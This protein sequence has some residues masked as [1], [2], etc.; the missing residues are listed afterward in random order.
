MKE[1]ETLPLHQPELLEQSDAGIAQQESPEAE[2]TASVKPSQC[3]VSVFDV[4]D[5]TFRSAMQRPLHWSVVWSD[6]MMTMF[7]LFLTM[8]AYQAAHQEFL[9]RKTPEIVGG[10]TIEALDS[11]KLTGQLQPINPIK[12]GLPFV[13]AG[14]LKKVERV[15]TNDVDIGFLPAPETAEKP[16]ASKTAK[17]VNSINQE[18]PKNTAK[19][20][21][22]IPMPG[23]EN[24][25]QSTRTEEQDIYRLSKEA[26]ENNKLEKFAS[27]DLVPDN[28]MRIIL[29][30]DLLFSTGQAELSASAKGSLQKLTEIMK[31]TPYM[32]NVVGH[33]D[34]IPM[35]SAKYT[36]NW[37]LSIARASA[38]A[39][40]LIDEKGMDPGQFVVS[41][42]ASFRPL[43]PNTDEA[44]RAKNRRVEIIISKHLPA[45]VPVTT[46]NI[47]Q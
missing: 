5:A 16:S 10:S 29:T 25:K 1:T 40:F 41:G 21:S 19:A 32:I 3:C 27:I 35:H 22:A 4:N 2:Q 18:Q 28:T 15:S 24:Q 44:S 7:I 33:T 11:D 20:I 26:L 14:T 46:E 42:Y 12:K 9:A 17:T 38:V 37:E 43:H 36:S 39:R 31:T 30:G 23:R 8:Y 34:N 47:H 13:T 45:P 6:L